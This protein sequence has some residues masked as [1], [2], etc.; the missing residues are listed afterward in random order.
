M[1]MC[2]IPN[3]IIWHTY[4]TLMRNALQTSNEIYSKNRGICMTQMERTLYQQK[5]TAE[6]LA[7]KMNG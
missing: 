5:T 4:R 3:R 6:F 7:H 1:Y 2:Q